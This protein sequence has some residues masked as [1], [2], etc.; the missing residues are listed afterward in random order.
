MDDKNDM[1]ALDWARYHVEHRDTIAA[2]KRYEEA[3]DEKVNIIMRK[4]DKIDK[5]R[6]AI[7]LSIDIFND[8]AGI[9]KLDIGHE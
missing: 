8:I 4:M 6:K 9:I 3:I 5:M 1:T 2:C 7:N